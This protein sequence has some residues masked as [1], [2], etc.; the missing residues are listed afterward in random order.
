MEGHGSDLSGAEQGQ[1]AGSCERGNE[2]WGS[3][4]PGEFL[5]Q[6]RTG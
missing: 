2:P 5:D 6:L 1:L 3:I 4:P